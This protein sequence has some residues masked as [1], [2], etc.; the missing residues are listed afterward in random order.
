VQL[1]CS[2][3]DVCKTLSGLAH[4]CTLTSHLKPLGKHTSIFLNGF[5]FW[6]FFLNICY[7]FSKQTMSHWFLI[8]HIYI[9]V[10]GDAWKSNT[11]NL[12]TLAMCFK[13][14][15]LTWVKHHIPW[16]Q[17]HTH[18][19][20]HTHTDSLTDLVWHMD[21]NFLSASHIMHYL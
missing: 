13:W 8:Y 6:I 3:S 7:L 14:K 19:H 21:S 9:P 10:M 1:V 11:S 16:M 5:L 4:I 2:M 12:M 20:T 17:A 15:S 18:T